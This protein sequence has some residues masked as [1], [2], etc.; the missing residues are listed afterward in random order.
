MEHK[1]PFIHL[2][3]ISA[4]R[5]CTWLLRAATSHDVEPPFATPTDPDV[6]PL[7]ACVFA[8][9]VSRAFISARVEELVL[10][11]LWLVATSWLRTSHLFVAAA[12]ILSR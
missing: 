8:P 9:L 3:Q 10:F 1:P 6:E 7:L 5:C 2:K 11:N 4:L 12:E